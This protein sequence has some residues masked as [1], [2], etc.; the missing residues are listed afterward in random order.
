MALSKGT[1]NKEISWV[2]QSGQGDYFM[3]EVLWHL[4]NNISKVASSSY[5]SPVDVDS[6]AFWN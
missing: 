3:W 2:W 4:S 6:S 1:S 5:S